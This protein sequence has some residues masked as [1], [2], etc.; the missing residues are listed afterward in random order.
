MGVYD[1]ENDPCLQEFAV[2]SLARM[3]RTDA[4]RGSERCWGSERRGFGEMRD[5]WF[6]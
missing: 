6:G 2:Y 3:V 4:C 5:K 1:N